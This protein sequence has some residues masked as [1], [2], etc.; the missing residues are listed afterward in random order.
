M[1]VMKKGAM[2]LKEGKQGYMRRF[3]G[4][5][6]NGK[7][8]QLYYNLKISNYKKKST[9]TIALKRSKN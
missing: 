7:S 3:G 1:H 9:Y 5:K 6:G 8:M 2:N 4:R